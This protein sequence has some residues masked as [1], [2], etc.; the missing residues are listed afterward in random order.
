[1]TRE[2][3]GRRQRLGTDVVLSER[4]MGDRDTAASGGL[5]T[6]GQEAEA[7]STSARDTPAALHVPPGARTCCFTHVL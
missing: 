7:A 6:G 2:G 5:T 3:G 4:K 1:V